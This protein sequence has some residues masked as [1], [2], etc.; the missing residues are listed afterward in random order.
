MLAMFSIIPM[1]KGESL[2]G[3]VAEAIDL[4]DGSGLKYQVTAMGT[5]VE[6]NWDEVM[7]LIKRCHD[8]VRKGSRRVYTRISIDDREGAADSIAGKVDSVEKKIG[9]KIRK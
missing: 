2:S 3:E 5:L 8:A 7:D 4:V 6:G 1:N 9:R